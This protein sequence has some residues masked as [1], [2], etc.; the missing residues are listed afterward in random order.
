MGAAGTDTAIETADVAL[1]ADDITRL[2]YVVDLSSRASSTIRTNIGA[3]LAMKALLAAGAPLGYVSVAMAVV[4]G[5]MGMSLGVTG[6]ALRLGNVEPAEPPSTD[7]DA[8]D[9]SA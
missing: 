5:D 6:N 2:P 3:S 1:M 9:P 4:V 8:A 7:P